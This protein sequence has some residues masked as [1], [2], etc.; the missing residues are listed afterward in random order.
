MSLES[1]EVKIKITSRRKKAVY[2]I[3][4]FIEYEIKMD[5]DDD[6]GTFSFSI[7]NVNGQYSG[8]F[9]M[10]D[11]VSCYVNGKLVMKGR[12]DSVEYKYDKT[13]DII[14]IEGRDYCQKLVD[15]DQ[16]PCKKSK[17]T[18]T[19]VKS[20]IKKI[21]KNRSLKCSIYSGSIPA[22][23]GLSIGCDESCLSVIQNLLAD[24]ELKVWWQADKLHINKWN[25]KGSAKYN[26]SDAGI[27]EVGYK[28][29]GKDIRTRVIMY[30]TDKKGKYH[31]KKTIKNG[32]IHKVIGKTSRH[33]KYADESRVKLKN[34]G[35][36]KMKE[37]YINILELNLKVKPTDIVY[38]P[39]S[40]AKVSI[41]KLGINT[42]FFIRGVTYAKDYD[43][44]TSVELTLIVANTS[45]NQAYKLKNITNTPK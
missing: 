19:N 25:L 39:N 22:F 44:G 17:K 31:K 41:S 40:C 18:K 43:T 33:K 12:V 24:T 34:A 8:Y 20:Y 4:N 36:K 15:N 32:S 29:N 27:E 7:G 3:K 11:K 45:Y 16:T 9:S 37:G 26:I 10:F 6:C 28:E 13:D 21:C 23:K 1:H 42:K 38:M 2:Q 14:V 30:Q 5:L 35:V